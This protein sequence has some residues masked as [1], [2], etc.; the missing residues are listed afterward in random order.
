ML[1]IL[2]AYLKY[3]TFVCFPQEIENVQF[4]KNLIF[5]TINCFVKNI[6]VNNFINLCSI[7]Q[8]C[9]LEVIKSLFLRSR[10]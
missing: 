9:V 4:L 10:R 5:I 8:S 6:F 7:C 1:N 2:K 3:R